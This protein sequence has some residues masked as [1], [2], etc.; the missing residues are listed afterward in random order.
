[1][2]PIV[3][4]VG[5]LQEIQGDPQALGKPHAI[6][7][8]L[9]QGTH[10]NLWAQ[11]PRVLENQQWAAKSAQGLWATGQLPKATVPVFLRHPWDSPEVQDSKVITAPQSRGKSGTPVLHQTP[12]FLSLNCTWGFENTG[13]FL[14][15]NRTWGF[16]NT[17]I[18]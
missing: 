5:G 10:S 8:V 3:T 1:M 17:G 18:P 6:T 15:L 12:I 13:I 9:Q 4:A 2:L 11:G 16:E 7:T 14:S